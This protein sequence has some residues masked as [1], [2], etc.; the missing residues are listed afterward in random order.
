VELR[1][2]PW[3]EFQVFLTVALCANSQRD[4]PASFIIGVEEQDIDINHLR[5]ASFAEM[6]HGWLGTETVQQSF[7]GDGW[8]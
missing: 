1:C 3:N 4:V 5:T 8:W 2:L 6:N 7:D